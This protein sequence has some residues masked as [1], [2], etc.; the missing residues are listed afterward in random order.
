MSV[1]EIGALLIE[2]NKKNVVEVVVMTMEVSIQRRSFG[3]AKEA[4]QR[5]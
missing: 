1:K 4:N 3:S 2:K 5:T